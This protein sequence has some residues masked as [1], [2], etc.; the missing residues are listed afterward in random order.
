MCTAPADIIAAFAKK[1]TYIGELELLAEIVPYISEPDRFA[2]KDVIHFVDNTSAIFISISN[3]SSS[4]DA[5]MLVHFLHMVLVA[6]DVSVWFEYVASK[7]NISDGPS[8]G[9]TGLL[10]GLGATFVEPTFPRRADV[11]SPT[12]AWDF[13]LRLR[14]KRARESGAVRA[15][16][17][18][19]RGH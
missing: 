14:S 9:D 19:A 12:A 7:S 18:R 5:A 16:R 3:Y 15:A 17:K 13:A 1:M 11:A 2:G 8:R 10:L 4:P 6:L